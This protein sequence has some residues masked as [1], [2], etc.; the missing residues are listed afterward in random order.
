[1]IST[2]S[3]PNNHRTSAMRW[4][5]AA[6]LLLPLAAATREEAAAPAAVPRRLPRASAAGAFADPAPSPHRHGV[7]VSTYDPANILDDDCSTAFEHVYDSGFVGTAGASHDVAHIGAESLQLDLGKSVLAGDARLILNDAEELD[8][9]ALAANGWSEVLPG[10]RIAVTLR[11]DTG[12]APSRL[13]VKGYVAGGVCDAPSGQSIC[14]T[15]DDRVNSTD[16][17]QGRIGGCTGWL[18]SEDVFIQAGHCGTPSASKRLHFTF[19]MSGAPVADQYAVEAGSYSGANGGGGNDWGVGRLLPNSQTGLLPGVAQSNECG[20]PGC[21]WYDLGPVPATA[22]GNDIRI[23]GYGTAVVANRRQKTHVG[24]LAHIGD[25]WLRYVPD[26]TG[27]NSG[28]P[29]VH[30]Q[31]GLAI[32]VHTHGGCSSTGGSNMGTR[33]DRADFAAAIN[34]LLGVSPPPAPTAPPVST[35]ALGADLK[36]EVLTDNYPGET[37][38]TLENVCESEQI[39]SGGPYATQTT[40]S[41]EVCDT[42][43]EFK[44]TIN[45]SWGDGICCNYGSGQYKV[46]LNGNVAI[47]GGDFDQTETKSFGSCTAPPTGPPTS[48]PT[49]PPTS[50]PTAPPTN[51]PT[52]PPTPPPPPPRP[53]SATPPPPETTPPPPETTPPS[54]WTSS[55]P[56][57]PSTRTSCAWTPTSSRAAPS[58]ASRASARTPAPSWSRATAS[59]RPARPASSPPRSPRPR[60]APRASKST[61]TSVS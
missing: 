11:S 33:I 43:G 50:P 34:A 46:Y 19:G 30:E 41:Q 36:V 12:G 1:M 27:G 57:S 40:F 23:T 24:G 18:I 54:S 60:T 49:A 5:V 20:S 4:S 38:W 56:V 51:P 6:L 2:S 47:E 28:S 13:V 58:A 16:P 8:A 9:A 37:T 45:D 55:T 42:P 35:C 3:S 32:G 21:G 26:T 59:S 10:A 25:T 22:A 15:T 39:A 29:V 53:L 7:P 44:F 14:G 31:T 17:R 52:N 61:T 48:P